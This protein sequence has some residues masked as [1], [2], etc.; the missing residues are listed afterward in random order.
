MK[1]GSIEEAKRLVSGLHS[2]ITDAEFERRKCE[3]VEQMDEM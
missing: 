2:G 3:V 1:T